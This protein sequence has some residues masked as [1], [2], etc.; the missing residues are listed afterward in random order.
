MNYLSTYVRSK[1]NKRGLDLPARLF[2]SLCHRVP[3]VVTVAAVEH[4]LFSSHEA[5]MLANELT[6]CDSSRHGSRW[7][8]QEEL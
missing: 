8:A 6:N 4:H 1:K 3:L 7:I 5:A 2:I